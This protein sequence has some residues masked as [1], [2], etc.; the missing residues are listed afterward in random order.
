MWFGDSDESGTAT[1]D[2]HG[3]ME[4]EV[5]LSVDGE[6]TLSVES[7]T[8]PPYSRYTVTV[9]WTGDR[10]RD[11]TVS[12]TSNDPDESIGT[13]AVQKADQGVGTLHDDFTLPGIELPDGDEGQ[14]TLSDTRG[15]A[16]VLVYWA[17]F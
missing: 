10:A 3:P 9:N 15:K 11:V 16:V 7:F 12:W 5:G 2:N 13:F 6:A 4:L 8:V 17:L 14:W 1:F